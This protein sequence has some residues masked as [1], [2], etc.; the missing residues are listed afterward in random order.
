MLLLVICGCVKMF[1]VR[2][3]FSFGRELSYIHEYAV[4]PYD[5]LK[6]KNALLKSVYCVTVTPFTVLLNATPGGIKNNY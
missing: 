5:I 3:H 4:K 2:S 6:V 1:P